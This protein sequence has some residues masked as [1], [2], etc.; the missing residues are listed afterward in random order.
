LKK[1]SA[2]Y[3]QRN[4]ALLELAQ[5]KATE[6]RIFWRTTELESWERVS[7]TWRV[8]GEKIWFRF[9]LQGNLL[10]RPVASVKSTP[11]GIN[12]FLPN[13]TNPIPDK[14][15]VQ[16]DEA[17]ADSPSDPHRLWRVI[18]TWLNQEY[19]GYRIRKCAKK[20]DRMRTLS[21]LFLRATFG[22]RGTEYLLI[23]ADESAGDDISLAVGQALLWLEV[24]N[25]KLLFGQLPSIHIL[26]PSSLSAVVHHRCKHIDPSQVRIE[27]WAYE[28]SEAELCKVMRA[29][30]P[31]EL[32]ENVDYHWPVLGPFRWSSNLEKVLGLAPDLISRYPRF[33][34]YDSLRLRGLEFA[35]VLGIERDCIHFGVGSSRTEL[36]PDNFDILRELI[37]EI[38]FYRRPD[39]PDMQHP[40]YRL[41]AER[42]LESLVLADIPR[43][44]PE[45]APEAVY[46]QIP[47]YL[48]RIPGRIDI[49]G[50]NVQGDLVIIELKVAADS[51]LPVQALDYW[52]RVIEHNRNGDFI[53]RGYFSEICLNRRPP[54]VYLVAP[55]F[56]FH[57]TTELLLRYLDPTLEIHK[58]AINENWRSGVKIF[59]RMRYSRDAQ[60]CIIKT[61]V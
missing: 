16:W 3:L 44:F 29:T 19:P 18:H 34:E 42:W 21:N 57:D 15:E 5:S 58:I 8:V 31:P 61:G 55:V 40:Y 27:V 47:V 6:A 25:P 13:P 56:S 59:N 33:Y 35:Q 28:T 30:A 17:A 51:D 1:P 48:G 7:P 49:L 12:L 43:L 23:A 45:M 50:A 22:H 32:K 24:V 39:S 60:K 11:W 26:A 53:R 41:Q 37:Q 10:D 36:T 9:H 2:T 20:T 14:F 38:L 52:G 4:L 46:S 54:S